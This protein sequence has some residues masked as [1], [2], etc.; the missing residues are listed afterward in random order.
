MSDQA[1]DFLMNWFDQHIRPLPAAARLAEATRLAVKCRFAATAAGIPLQEIRD[2][3]GGD[4]IRKILHA[5][6]REALLPEE[7]PAP[8]LATL[9]DN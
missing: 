3:T 8:E 1:R 5:L 2:A 9:V 7:I 6:D 4:L